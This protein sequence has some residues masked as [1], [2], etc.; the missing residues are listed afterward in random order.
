MNRNHKIIDVRTPVE[1][2]SGHVPGSLNIPLAEIMNRVDEIREIREP[3]ILCCASGIR[4]AHAASLLRSE[5]IE[6]EDGGS[7]MVV[8]SKF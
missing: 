4:S 5:G 2:I 7:W 8:L 1:Y 6:C 3:I